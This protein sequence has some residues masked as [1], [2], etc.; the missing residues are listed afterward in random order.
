M[1]GPV[2]AGV[3][4]AALLAALA[5]PGGLALPAPAAADGL[6]PSFTVCQGPRDV[7][8]APDSAHAY[9]ACSTGDTLREL[10]RA[11]GGGWS[12]G[13]SVTVGDGPI[14]VALSAD[15]ATAYV[16]N[17]DSDTVS[18][19]TV[20]SMVVASTIPATQVGDGPSS[21]AVASNGDLYLIHDGDNTLAWLTHVSQ[22]DYWVRSA[23]REFGP[24]ELLRDLAVSP[25]GDLFVGLNG[26]GLDVPSESIVRVSA[27][28]ATRTG[29]PTG[30]VSGRIAVSPDGARVYAADTSPI[31][32]GSVVVLETASGATTVW[33]GVPGPDDIA[34]SP[35]GA[36]LYLAAIGDQTHGTPVHTVAVIDTGTGLRA[37][38]DLEFTNIPTAISVTPDSTSAITVSYGSWQAQVLTLTP[39]A[40]AVSS[41]T[42]AGTPRVDEVLTSS[43]GRVTGAPWP[44]TVS[45]R[46]QASG[47]RDGE[48][49][50]IGGATSATYTVG[51]IVLGAW[52]RLAVTAT[53]GAGTSEVSSAP[54]GPV[55]DPRLIGTIDVGGD[56][57][58]MAASP[59]RSRL[60]VDAYTPSGRLT[61]IDTASGTVVGTFTHD[62]FV[63]SRGA[64]VAPDGAV[65]W[66]AGMTTQALATST[67]AVVR[68]V[69][70]P[71]PAGA[72][73]TS[74]EGI[75]VSP[76]GARVYV[77]GRDAP[78]F[79]GPWTGR[80]WRIAVASGAVTLLASGPRFDAIAIAPD[81]A[82]AYVTHEANLQSLDL[83]TDT[84]GPVVTVGADLGGIAVSPD[85]ARA[86]VSTTNAVAVVDLAPMTVATTIPVADMPTGLTLSPDGT[87]LYVALRYS[88][89]T[90]AARALAVV[91]TRTLTATAWPYPSDGQGSE[92]A[93]S[94]DGS[95]IFVSHP[96]TRQVAM[97][98]ADTEPPA[99][100]WATVS[101]TPRVG[102]TLTASHGAVTGTP[103]PQVTYRWQ[104]APAVG[105]P[106]TDVPGAVLAS[107]AV[108]DAV[109]G[110][111]LRAIAT[112]TSSAGVAAVP[113]A[114]VG[115]VAAR[116]VPPS[117]SPPVPTPPTP[118]PPTAAMTRP[119]AAL[120]LASSATF[121]WT[122]TDPDSAIT[123]FDLLR[124][125]KAPGAA[126]GRYAAWGGPRTARSAVMTGLRPGYA[127]CLRV[128]ARDAT[129][130]LSGWSSPR[131]VTV[132]GD[133]RT[134]VAGRGWVRSSARTAFLGTV[135]ASR[136]RGA[137]LVVARS[138]GSG[139]VVLVTAQPGGGT[140]GVYVRGK[141]VAAVTT[142]A[143]RVATRVLLPV[144]VRTTG[145][146]VVLRVDSPG[147]RGIV[148]DG[149][150]QLP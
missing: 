17:H 34:L 24:S 86:Y 147:T 72:V 32:V 13:R 54:V 146:P 78:E 3:A 100:A 83:A 97:L 62:A 74:V 48:F 92:V 95:R 8:I 123:S 77:L 142:A 116:P 101:G 85:S 149:V 59:G 69:M 50:N 127:Y 99:L 47:T 23:G 21:I 49:V 109:G 33:D 89:S 129:G 22:P 15:G 12:I 73:Y 45:Y 106:W 102:D 9:V 6:S 67:G 2:I 14:S 87:R 145:Q 111:W 64:A 5:G 71:T 80:L 93:T 96:A 42:I 125:V 120:T 139:L 16:A 131:C 132:P 150:A 43:L 58:S 57:L 130:L 75:A 53:N 28:L 113:T 35:D 110:R 107:Y 38:P 135:S 37:A 25:S 11:A 68:S 105:G 124:A 108:D 44:V 30:H 141:R 60:Y 81:G 118:R 40:P 66:I 140:L 29:W 20:A 39:R 4:A 138:Y 27:T 136:I 143:R 121:A 19:V 63:P 133:D 98:R 112:A 84:L 41:V 36:R 115:P 65:V 88:V 76:D 56:A 70:L 46:W 122:G 144:R 82:H 94:A 18:I 119:T 7:A 104:A 90:A 126:V 31:G 61:S 134:L 117:P 55:Q 51:P 114:P 91:D 148:V 10:T 26:Q 128:R 52:V 79:E 103:M 137:A 1:R